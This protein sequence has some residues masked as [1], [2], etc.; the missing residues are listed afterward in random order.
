MERMSPE[1]E[2]L[3]LKKGLKNTGDAK[4]IYILTLTNIQA[5]KEASQWSAICIWSL[6]EKSKHLYAISITANM[7]SKSQVLNQLEKLLTFTI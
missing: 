3:Q 1:S 6:C 4:S 5:V 7:K 2:A